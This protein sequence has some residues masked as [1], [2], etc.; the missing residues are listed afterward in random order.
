MI[1]DGKTAGEASALCGFKDY[2]N[3]FRA[4]K[5]EYGISPSGVEKTKEV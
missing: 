4:F 5:A 2:T 3:F 1:A